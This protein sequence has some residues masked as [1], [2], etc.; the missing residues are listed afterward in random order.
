MFGCDVDLEGDRAVIGATFVAL[1]NDVTGAAFVFLKEAAGWT[2]EDTLW[3]PVAVPSMGFG[4]SVA[5][6]GDAAAVSAEGSPFSQPGGELVQRF[7]RQGSSWTPEQVYTPGPGDVDECF[8]SDLAFLDGGLDL[9]VGNH[10]DG[11]VGGSALLIG[12]GQ[13]SVSGASKILLTGAWP[14]ASFGFSVGVSGDHLI[15]GAPSAATDGVIGSGAAVIYSL[16]GEGCAPLAVDGDAI[17]IADGGTAH[18]LLAAGPAS[19]GGVY[20]LLGSASGTE[21]GQSLGSLVLPLNADAYLDF[22]LVQPNSQLLPG[23]L[24]LFDEHGLPTV[25]VRLE[26]P[27]A[28]A[29]PELAGLTLEHAYLL[30]DSLGTQGIT[31]VSNAA[32]VTLLP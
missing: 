16:S 24:G 11:L 28:L 25:S 4:S 5:I 26:L 14:Y 12:S 21:P 17:S 32:A 29:P 3:P 30:F 7:R 6:A 1:G 18:F 8:A 27:P 19:A 9:V 2:L 20:L 15:V 10:C 22:T 23:S 13:E 31:A